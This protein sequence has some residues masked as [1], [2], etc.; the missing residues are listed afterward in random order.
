MAKGAGMPD[1]R[2]SSVDPEIR[3]LRSCGVVGICAAVFLLAADWTLM[4]S[5]VSGPEFRRRWHEILSGMPPWRLYVGGLA[6][7]VGACLYAVGFWHVYLAVRPA[8]RKVALAVFASLTLSF[9]LIAGGFH[10]ALPFVAY[11]W[12]S[13]TATTVPAVTAPIDD[14]FQYAKAIYTLGLIPGFVGMALLGYAVLTGRTRY[15]RSFVIWNPGLLYVATYLFERLPAPMGGLLVIGAGNLVFLVF[16]AA[17][18]VVV[19]N[20]GRVGTVSGGPEG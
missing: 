5:F 15:R 10:T 9:A 1:A 17:S 3:L 20:G 11:A 13:R 7:P 4:G 12:Q 18:V 16:F 2:A 6:G 8:G 19:W 14:L